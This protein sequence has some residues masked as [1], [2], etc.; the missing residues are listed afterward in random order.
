[1]ASAP[2]AVRYSPA[3]VIK[4]E[5]TVVSGTPDVTRITTSHTDGNISLL[6]Q[7]PAIRAKI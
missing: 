3:E 7:V 5:K 2:A 6:L 4:V 1:M